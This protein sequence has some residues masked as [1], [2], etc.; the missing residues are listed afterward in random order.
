MFKNIKDIQVNKMDYIHVLIKTINTIRGKGGTP[1]QQVMVRDV[2]GNEATFLQFDTMLE[3]EPPLIAKIQVECIEYGSSIAFKIKNLEETD[4]CD[5]TAFLPKAHINIKDAWSW[6][7]K[8]SK[9]IREGLCRILCAVVLEDKNKFVTLPLKPSGAFAR[10]SGLFEATIKLAEM[11]E[12]AAIQQ[13]LDRD[14]MVTA[15]L[16]YFTGNMETVD[17]GYK[18]TVTDLMYGSAITSLIK[19]QSKAMFLIENNQDARNCISGEDV[20][21]LCHIMAARDNAVFPTIPEAVALKHLAHMLIEVDEMN[22][23]LET[24]ESSINID[25]KNKNK[26]VYKRKSRH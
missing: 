14:L 17:E 26:R 6:F 7:V 4:E 20:M 11:A 18:T 19:V 25:F 22:Q 5:M 12:T 13:N 9:T 2:D 24:A 21:M 23:V 3:F 10:Q 16:L 1:Y 8:K 15:A